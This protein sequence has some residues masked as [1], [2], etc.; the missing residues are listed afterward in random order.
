MKPGGD[1]S[2]VDSPPLI[3]KDRLESR[4]E[5]DL[6]SRN[7]GI[8]PVIVFNSR[9]EAHRSFGFEPRPG[10]DARQRGHGIEQTPGAR[11][12]RGIYLFVDRR[13]EQL[14]LGF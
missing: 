11:C 9:F 4:H 13:K 7:E 6:G 3:L 2:C 14:Q 5:P 8:H 1:Y 10:D 12:K